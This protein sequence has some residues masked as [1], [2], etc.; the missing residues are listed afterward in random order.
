[1]GEKSDLKVVK[2]TSTDK[3]GVIK[4]GQEIPT[5]KKLTKAEQKKL[6]KIKAEA[7]KLQA[8]EQANQMKMQIESMHKVVQSSICKKCLHCSNRD[9]TRASFKVKSSKGSERYVPM[10]FCSYAGLSLV[11]VLECEMFEEYKG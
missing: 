1:M 4:P 8:E 7:I 9:Q 11:D 5:P 2:N 3:I 10:N 6:D